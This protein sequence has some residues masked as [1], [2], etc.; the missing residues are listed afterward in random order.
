MLGTVDRVRG[1]EL[2]YGILVENG[3]IEPFEDFAYREYLSDEEVVV[4]EKSRQVGMSFC[5][6]I[7]CL[8]DALL[9]SSWVIFSESKEEARRKLGYIRSVIDGL[10][11]CGYDLGIRS[12]SRD[13]IE[14]VG[15]GSIAVLSYRG[16]RGRGYS[17]NIL[18]DEC[19]WVPSDVLSDL[20]VRINPARV[21]VGGLLR[22]VGSSSYRGHYLYDS[23][24]ISRVSR[25]SY[26]RW[27]DSRY[28]CV[29]VESAR[30]ECESLSTAVRVE[31]YG[32]RSLK[33]L[34]R[35]YGSDI[36]FARE[37]ECY[38]GDLPDGIVS[39]D[40]L[41]GC[42]DYDL[43][44]GYYEGLVGFSSFLESVVD[45]GIS[46][47][48]GVDLGRRNNHTEIV[49]VDIDGNVLYNID[50]G[51]IR[52]DEQRLVLSELLDRGI[53]RKMYIDESGLGMDLVEHMYSR[54][55]ERVVGVS[56]TVQEKHSLVRN[57]SRAIGMG[58][59]RIYPLKDLL[60][61]ILDIRIEFTNNGNIIYRV[62]NSRH[63]GDKFWALCLALRG[64]PGLEFSYSAES[65]YYSLPSYRA[66]GTRID[67][68]RHLRKGFRFSY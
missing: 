54:Y 63:N 61:Q 33:Q 7:R 64:L 13:F 53:V 42:V 27:W 14:F 50:L 18:V 19:F 41:M 48:C 12:L 29:D 44:G 56:F 10:V 15:G 68:M 24:Y 67:Y 16:S 66:Y 45:R 22:L 4:I 43:E 65:D 31:R 49:L 39:Y 21:R 47:Y 11:R 6:S 25:W 38:V 2:F 32:T 55:S 30:R 20:L 35:D 60:K 1:R 37:M 5:M 52:F 36:D 46:F 58:R 17:G 23:G 57:F 28:F 9:G 59:I 40:M 34:Y 8:V 3:L 62:S 51:T 26:I